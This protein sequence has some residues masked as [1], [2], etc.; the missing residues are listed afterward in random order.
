[1]II[2]G[3]VFI[4]VLGGYYSPKFISKPSVN[5]EKPTVTPEPTEI[6][7]PAITSTP[8][9]TPIPTQNPYFLRRIEEIDNRISEIR[10]K[11]EEAKKMME[12]AIANIESRPRV[13]LEDPT[14]KINAIV[15]IRRSYSERIKNSNEE[16]DRLNAEKT[17]IMINLN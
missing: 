5:L 13:Y 11:D 7:T 17:Q 14:Y 16:I 1:M 2:A 4:A 3:I 8:I 9:P 15:S 12:E 6:P 10:Q